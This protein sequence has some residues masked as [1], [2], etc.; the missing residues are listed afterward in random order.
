MGYDINKRGI[1]APSFTPQ[2][3]G[4]QLDKLAHGTDGQIPIANTS[5]ATA[6]ATVSGILALSAAG[7]LSVS[8]SAAAGLGLFRVAH[9][10]YSFAIDG[11]ATGEIIPVGSPTIPDNAIIIGGI[12]NPSTALAATGG[13]ANIAIG[14]HAG[15]ATNSLKAA[16]AKGTY[17]TDALL[18]LTPTWTANWFKMTAAG[19]MSITVDTNPLT[20]GV[21]EVMCVYFLPTT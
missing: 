11:G 16:T 19:Q 2:A 5:A 4:I 21:L 3:T 12:A 8:Q 10:K 18:A 20:S 15:S 13:A 14:T 6:Y 17:T 9:M 1:I 7:V